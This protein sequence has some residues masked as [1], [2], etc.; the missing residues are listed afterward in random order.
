MLSLVQSLPIFLLTNL[1][2]FRVQNNQLN[3]SIPKEL[4]NLKNLHKLDLANNTYFIGPIPTTISLFTNL[5]YLSVQYNR[6]TGELPHSLANLTQLE[7]FDFPYNFISG[8]IPKELGN[9]KY[10]SYL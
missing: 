10:L 5:T 7:I 2:Y 4:G 6:L 3:N 1:T 8:S 9:L